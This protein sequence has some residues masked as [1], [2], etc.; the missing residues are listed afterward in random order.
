MKLKTFVARDPQE[1][2]AQVKR[3]LGPEAVILSTQTR[4]P[5]SPGSRR[6]ATRQ[7]EVTAAVDQRI[8]LEALAELQDWPSDLGDPGLSPAQLKEELQELKALVKQWLWEH[9]P[10]VWL[11]PY[12]DLNRLFQ[13]LLRAG[14][15]EQIMGRWLENVRG[16]LKNGKG[17]SRNNFKELA[18]QQLM[19]E[20]VVVDPWKTISKR[21]RRWTF[22]GATG[23]GKTTTVA[24]LAIQAAY[25]KKIQVGLISLDSVRPGAQDHLAAYARIGELPLFNAQTRTDLAE[26][27]EKMD[28]LDLILIDT[29]GRNPCDPALPLELFQLFGDF[30]G[31]EHHLVV[32]ATA[33]EGNLVDAL[34]GF[35]L[36]PL[37]SCIV[38]KVDEVRD[39]VGVFN[40]ICSRRLP[41]SFLTTGQRIPEDLE[42]ASRRRL[43]GLLLKPQYSQRVQ[44]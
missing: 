1:A 26:T 33:T 7:V 42:L 24:K 29:P 30:P 28:Q 21:R 15:H 13:A 27:L 10:P 44:R 38:T 31:L 32:S 43:A 9:G 41:F 35:H 34:Q 36:E 12:K 5:H 37:A 22:L 40:Q 17:E 8:A 11:A 14:V 18:L 4:P 16:C 20:V 2:L 3:E 23:V 25:V 6:S 39:I 19:R